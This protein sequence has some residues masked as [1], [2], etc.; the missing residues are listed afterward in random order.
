MKVLS[1][2]MMKKKSAA[3]I[4]NV[5]KVQTV[6]LNC[7]GQDKWKLNNPCLVNEVG[8]FS[9]LAHVHTTLIVEKSKLFKIAI[10]SEEEII[11]FQWNSGLTLTCCQLWQPLQND[12]ILEVAIQIQLHLLQVTSYM[13]TRFLSNNDAEC[14]IWCQ[15]SSPL[16][17]TF[18]NSTK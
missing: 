15:F 14:Y 5:W 10:I 17:Y 9:L 11:Q 7:V 1:D 12:E 6:D 16:T 4:L 3:W 2:L 13:H 18:L 8:F